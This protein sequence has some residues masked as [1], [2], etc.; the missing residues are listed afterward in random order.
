MATYNLN[1]F[2]DAEFDATGKAVVTLSPPSLEYWEISSMAVVTTDPTDSTVVPEARVTLDG[3]F[4]EG[5][6]SGNLDAS[7]TSYRIEKGQQFTCTWT[8]GTPGRT[9]TFTVN[10]TRSTY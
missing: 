7:D 10:G 5:S 4:K 3:V 8:G 2:S 9:A 6:Y 1:A